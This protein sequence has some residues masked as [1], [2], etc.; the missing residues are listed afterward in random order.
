MSGGHPTGDCAGAGRVKGIS[1]ILGNPGRQHNDQSAAAL[2]GADMLDLF[3]H[4][5]PSRGELAREIGAHDLCLRR[6]HLAIAL[7]TRL[8]QRAM[9]VHAAH[10]IYYHFGA[11]LA[12]IASRRDGWN[13]ALSV[14]NSALELFTLNRTRGGVNVLD[15]ASVHHGWQSPLPDAGLAARNARKDAEIA[16]ADHIFTCS[17]MARQ[18]YIQA[19]VGGDRVHVVPLGLDR[20][21][22]ADAAAEN[23]HVGPI[24]FLFVARSGYA[25]GADLVAE[26]MAALAARGI[27]C[28]L[29]VAGRLTPD[30]VGWLSPHARLH[31]DVGREDL[32]RLM[33]EADII[34]HP[35]RFDSFGFV[36]AEALASGRGVI[37]SDRTGAADLLTPSENGWIIPTGDAAALTDAM[38]NA[39][40]NVAAVRAMA[41]ACQ[42]AV[43]GMNWASYRAR[44][45]ALLQDIAA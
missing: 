38:E 17:K 21:I 11:R 4:G 26:A 31:G 1:V 42:A 7:A 22:F 27:V 2:A 23:D 25:K 8:P 29:E 16:L 28:S 37:A 20:E 5:A 41:P 15:A 32:A 36:V 39:A 24:R 14:E 44:I 33:R 30:A 45:V 43:A 10:Q 9:R 12:R 18:S 19:G 35:S 40:A 3:V 6:Y 34:L 13:I